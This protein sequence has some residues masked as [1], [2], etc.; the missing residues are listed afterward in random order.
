MNLCNRH[1]NLMKS[2]ISPILQMTKLK[3]IK[4]LPNIAENLSGEARI[5]GQAVW[6]KVT[7]IHFRPKY[8]L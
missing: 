1:K 6:C 7:A 5:G 3:L 4:N 8:H 2:F